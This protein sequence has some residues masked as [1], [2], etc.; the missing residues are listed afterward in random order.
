[1]LSDKEINELLAEEKPVPKN[2]RSKLLPKDKTNA[3]HREREFKIRGVSGNNFIV[4]VRENVSLANDF[5][6]GIRYVSPSG[7]HYRLRRYNGNSHKHTNHLER[8]DGEPDHSFSGEFH[9]HLATE[10]YLKKRKKID[11]YAEISNS[12][13][14]LQTALDMLVADGIIHVLTD[15]DPNQT[16]MTW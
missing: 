1:M 2:W 9:I 11:G 10:R 3:F 13:S 7:V 16:Y 12:F 15:D 14:S 8:L 6:V 5:T 4:F